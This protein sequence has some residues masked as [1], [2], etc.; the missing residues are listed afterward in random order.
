MPGKRKSGKSIVVIEPPPTPLWENFYELDPEGDVILALSIP[1]GD[2][3]EA[4]EPVPNSTEPALEENAMEYITDGGF[5]YVGSSGEKAPMD[6]ASI[7]S[8]RDTYTDPIIPPV[9]EPPSVGHCHRTVDFRVSAAHLRLASPVF[10]G[11][12]EQYNVRPGSGRKSP[13]AILL[14]DDD[15]YSLFTLLNILHH[16]TKEVP[17]KISFEGLVRMAALVQKYD[18]VGVV[19]VHSRMWWDD[20]GMRDKL[21][22]GINDKLLQFLYIGRLF[23]I[24][25]AFRRASLV[26]IRESRGGDIEGRVGDF[27][28]SRSILTAIYEKRQAAIAGLL[29]KLHNLLE[30]YETSGLSTAYPS[31]PMCYNGDLACD[32]MVLGSLRK[33][34]RAAGLLP[35]PEPP[36]ERLSFAS[37]VADLEMMR[38]PS[39]CPSSEFAW[40]GVDAGRCM[41]D[42]LNISD[43]KRNLQ[44]LKLCDIQGRNY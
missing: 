37:L 43:L 39:S 7:G 15:P 30:R 36:Y 23:G 1:G 33:G 11:L 44:G 40:G 20:E 28:L 16:R 3:P 42:I 21:P 10:R 6:V 12:L 19:E 22:E 27:T 14:Q 18:C 2:A 25:G 17:N 32:A 24:P 13:V 26:A 41:K 4:A 29:A 34:M 38:M 9:S 8:E 35:P 31:G 5:T